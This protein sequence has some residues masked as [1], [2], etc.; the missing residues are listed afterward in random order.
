MGQVAVVYR[1]M[2]TGIEIDMKAMAEAARKVIPPEAKIQGMQ[3]KDIAYGLK[4]LLMRI[5]MAD[6]GGIQDKVEAALAKVPNVENV[7]VIDI[8]L[9]S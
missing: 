6:A 3:I 8:D 2:P 1:L 5:I 9:V 7:E 4:A